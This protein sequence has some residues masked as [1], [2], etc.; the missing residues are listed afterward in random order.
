MRKCADRHVSAAG[1]ELS[2]S[3]G[4]SGVRVTG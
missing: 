4:E 2:K 1:S 3:E